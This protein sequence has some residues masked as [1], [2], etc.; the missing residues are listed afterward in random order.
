MLART[1][2][3]ASALVFLAAPGWAQAGPGAMFDRF[4]AD[5][6]GTITYEEVQAWRTSFF[7]AADADEDGFVTRAELDAAQ[8]EAQARSQAGAEAQ[9]VE[10]R[11]GGMRRGRQADPIMRHD[12]DGDGQLSRTE[13]VHAPFAALE[14][15][16]SNGDGQLTRDEMPGRRGG[17]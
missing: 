8:A 13:F 16:D 14:R 5:S 7:D 1:L 2:F 9:G 12:S 4:D 17:G 6:D 11:R 3:S 10:R 15:F